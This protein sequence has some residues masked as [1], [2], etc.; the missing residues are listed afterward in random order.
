MYFDHTDKGHTLIVL[1][2]F[3]LLLAGFYYTI[4]IIPDDDSI[5]SQGMQGIFGGFALYEIL[6][7]FHVSSESIQQNLKTVMLKHI[8]N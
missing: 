7:L 3:N 2:S 5:N 8:S 1:T 6:F 4:K